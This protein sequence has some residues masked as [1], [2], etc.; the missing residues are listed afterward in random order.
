M[1]TLLSLAAALTILS[2]LG[3]ASAIAEGGD[4][5]LRRTYTGAPGR[6]A[7]GA[8]VVAAVR[9]KDSPYENTAPRESEAKEEPRYRPIDRIFEGQGRPVSKVKLVRALRSGSS[10]NKLS[11]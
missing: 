8:A 7:A 4:P 3:P 11:R 9:C 5:C 1:R 6:G 2:C 10:D